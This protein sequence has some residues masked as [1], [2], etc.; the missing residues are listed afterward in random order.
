MQ[1]LQQV[2]EEVEAALATKIEECQRIQQAQSN[3]FEKDSE[4]AKVKKDCEQEIFDISQRL[5]EKQM[6]V[7]SYQTWL[8]TEIME[9]DKASEEVLRIQE[10]LAEKK[11][12]IEASSVE[13]KDLKARIAVA[14]EANEALSAAKAGSSPT[15]TEEPMAAAISEDELRQIQAAAKEKIK[16]VKEKS[17]LKLASLKQ[18]LINM[19]KCVK[20]GDEEIAKLTESL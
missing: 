15:K 9:K 12:E 19:D 6:E 1:A 17:A 18:E 8:N 11:L 7:Q 16:D 13:N 2:N 5:S 14:L 3:V 10:E 4:L 20:E